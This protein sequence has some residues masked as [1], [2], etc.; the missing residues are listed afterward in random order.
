MSDESYYKIGLVMKPHGLKGEVTISLDEDS[1]Q[2]F[3]DLESVFLEIDNQFVPFFIESVSVRGEKAFVKFDDVSGPEAAGKISKR[4]VYLPKSTRPKSDKG[5]FY[6]D[7]IIGF[8]V[9]DETHG[10]LGKVTDVIQTGLN[11][12][13]VV[14]YNNKEVLIPINSPLLA[15]IN[16]NKKKIKVNLPDGFL[17]I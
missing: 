12:L 2:D 3:A 15:D 4:S 1:P 9:T 7:E 14:G 8:E 17:D 11:R 13:L 6:N 5:E 16:K 10:L